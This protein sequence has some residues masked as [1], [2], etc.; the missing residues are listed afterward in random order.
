MG[1]QITIL[2][3]L[4]QVTQGGI[5]VETKKRGHKHRIVPA[6]KKSNLANVKKRP[7]I[8]GDPEDLVHMVW[9]S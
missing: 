3:V 6:K 9:L 4:D 8:K 5:P 1:R 2:K 7:I